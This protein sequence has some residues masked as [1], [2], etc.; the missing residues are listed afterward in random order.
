MA[1]SDRVERLRKA[2]EAKGMRLEES[3]EPTARRWGL[4]RDLPPPGEPIK[5]SGHGLG[6][7]LDEVEK[8]LRE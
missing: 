1:D 7:T 5:E 2:A 3:Q 6:M 8:A 4:T